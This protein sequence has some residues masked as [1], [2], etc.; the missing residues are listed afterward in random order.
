MR[1][2]HLTHQL[3]QLINFLSRRETLCCTSASSHLASVVSE[4]WIST[5]DDQ[6]STCYLVSHL[7]EWELIRHPD[8]MVICQLYEALLVTY[9]HQEV[10]R[11]RWLVHTQVAENRDSRMTRLR[12]NIKLFWAGHSLRSHD[13][14]LLT[15]VVWVTNEMCYSRSTSLC[16]W[17]NCL[18]ERIESEKYL[19][20]WSALWFIALCIAVPICWLNKAASKSPSLQ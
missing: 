13:T 17:F 18:H 19:L 15:S 14:H 20:P 2:S 3:Y 5:K 11:W 12:R 10:P 16:E 4:I 9:F 6:N 1:K 7:T 8:D